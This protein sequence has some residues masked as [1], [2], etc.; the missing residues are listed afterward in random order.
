MHTFGYSHLFPQQER[1]ESYTSTL[2]AFPEETCNFIHPAL[3]VS[4][5]PWLGAWIGLEI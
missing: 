5:N 3:K 2:T 4:G 1:N